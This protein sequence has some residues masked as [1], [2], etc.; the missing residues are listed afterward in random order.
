MTDEL[1]PGG[2][3]FVDSDGV[4][5]IGTDSILLADFARS[6]GIK[7]KKRAADLGCGSGVIS[8]LLAWNDPELYVDGVEINPEAA[9][10]ASENAGA[11]CLSGRVAVI[12]GDL[13]RHRAFLQAGAY[14]ITISN[15]PYYAPGSGKHPSNPDL[16]SARVEGLCTLDDVCIAAGYLT[17]WGGSFMLVHKP[18]RLADVFRSLSS[19]GFEPKRARFVQHKHDS[20]PNL[21]LIESRRGGKPTLKVEAPLIL[22]NDDGS[23]SEEVKRIYRM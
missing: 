18:E 8:V 23:C 11:N 15:P 4:F 20:P 14:D 13:R 9:R 10:L 17:R 3:R 16:V 5:R 2:P 19:A 1:W 6:P 22:A 12:Q 7:K 21:T